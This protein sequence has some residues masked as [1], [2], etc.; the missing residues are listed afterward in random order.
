MWVEG[1]ISG[2]T[3]IV[4]ACWF[5]SGLLLAMTFGE[6]SFS[7]FKATFKLKAVYL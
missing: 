4:R 1:R 6:C 3:E 7:K 5:G 2:T